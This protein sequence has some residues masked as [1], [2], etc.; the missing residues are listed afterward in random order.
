MLEARHLLVSAR[1]ATAHIFGKCAGEG[2]AKTRKSSSGDCHLGCP[3]RERIKGL[4]RTQN[5]V[6]QSAT[7]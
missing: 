5:T 7:I 6:S 3:K 2:V 4:S 1:D